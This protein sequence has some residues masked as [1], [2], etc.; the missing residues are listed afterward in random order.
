MVVPMNRPTPRIAVTGP[1]GRLGTALMESDPDSL[2]WRRPGYDLDDPDAPTR[3]LDLDQPDLVVHAA[4]WTDVDGCARDPGLAQRRNGDAVTALARACVDRG[5]GLV[6]VST[7]EV[8]N[9]DRVDGQGYR[10]DDD[11]RPRNAYGQSKLAGELAAREVFGDGPGLWIARTAWLYGPPGNDFPT[12][13]VAAA[14][15]LPEGEA[16]RV[17]SD[18]VGSP[19]FTVDLAAAILA[20]IAA[21]EGGVY[22]LVNAGAVSRLEVAQH[23]LARLRPTRA[24]RPM[25]RT[26]FTRASDA[27][28]WAV[29][30]NA[31]AAAAGATLRRWS[32]AL[33]A[34]VDRLAAPA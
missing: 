20:L 16:L 7:N 27:P 33:D 22:H 18:E 1:G 10:E 9:G 17:V 32:D 31:R 5:V 23:V 34:Y 26:E 13:I 12:K 6:V 4:A 15:R 24:V 3:L 25:S 21:T 8:F 30:D 29:L 11:T 28:P 2:P 14:D 19:T